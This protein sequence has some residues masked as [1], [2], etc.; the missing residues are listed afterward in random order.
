ML[1]FIWVC[2]NVKKIM[3]V[4]AIL[5]TCSV[6]IYKSVIDDVNAQQNQKIESLEERFGAIKKQEDV[7]NGILM[8]VKEDTA[9]IRSLLYNNWTVTRIRF[10]TFRWPLEIRKGAINDKE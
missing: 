8:T 10:S 5:A 9:A 2:N 4:L 1:M 6:A 3:V 7:N